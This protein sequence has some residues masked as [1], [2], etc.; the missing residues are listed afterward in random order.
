MK[1]KIYL[2]SVLKKTDGIMAALESHGI[3]IVRRG[4]ALGGETEPD[5]A[6]LIWGTVRGPERNKE[7]AEFDNV[8]FAENGWFTQQDCCYIDK[9]GT[10][11]LSSIRGAVT[12]ASRVDE[13]RVGRFIRELHSR[14]DLT[15]VPELPGYIFVPL[16]VEDD[17]QITH[18]SN[19][20]TG[21]GSRQLWFVR[22]V[23][24][25][26]PDERI[27]IRPH[28]GDLDTAGLIRTE[29]AK[30][31]NASFRHDG[32]SYRWLR[33]AKA[34]VGI[35][36]TVLLEALTF[37]RPVCAMGTGL[38]S[39]NGVLLECAGDHDAIKRV[40]DYMPDPTRIT[41]FLALLLERQIPFDA[42]AAE[43]GRYPV[44]AEMV[45]RCGS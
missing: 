45:E 2:H 14:M 3:E 12:P 43:I 11:A 6:H 15:N 1:G 4:H 29:C 16:Q 23:C 35:N 27:V 36:S 30:Y 40:L 25:A 22:R 34:V 18:W 7:L 8:F 13:G 9:K 26:F 17:M 41:R 32:N 5:G 39:D 24:E 33:G 44:L 20:E 37:Y 21:N 19:C 42:S 38:F 10:N 31:K 28:P